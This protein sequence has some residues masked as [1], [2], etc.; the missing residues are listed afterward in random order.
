MTN[1]LISHTSDL[2]GAEKSLLDLAIGLKQQNISCLV[3]CPS[4]G[5]LSAKLEEEN[6]PVSYMNLPRPQRDSISLLKFILLWFPTVINLSYFLHSKRIHVVYNNTID[7]LYG[8]FASRISGIPCI[9]HVREVKPFNAQ[10]RK[11]FT[12]LL[13]HLPNITVFNSKATMKAYS[14]KTYPNWR[15][16]YNGVEISSR[17]PG[18][19]NTSSSIVLVGFAGQMIAH[20]CPEC[21]I[22]A[23]AVAQRE[24]PNLV[25]VMAGDGSM[26]EDMKLL[27]KKLNI[28]HCLQILGRV[29]DMPKF[30]KNLDIFVLTSEKEPFGRVLIE[31][32]S[33]GCPVIAPI[34][35]GVPEVVEDGLSGF[36]VKPNDTNAFAE[37][38]LKLARDKDLRVQIGLAGYNRVRTFFSVKEYC[39]QVINIF[40]EVAK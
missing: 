9:W 16:I 33:V 5:K 18:T 3:L 8:P 21:F 15:V 2:N 37:N 26:L 4:A 27:T 7:G 40:N 34:I 12:W 32:M 11:L 14:N 20:K 17:P 30:Y 29:T 28:S 38:I 36:L 13:V 1:L 25:G 23:F 6:I 35:D 22:R 39:S 10:V 24:F 19:R 31:A